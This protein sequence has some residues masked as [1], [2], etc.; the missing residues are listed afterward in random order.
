MVCTVPVKGHIAV[1]FFHENMQSGGDYETKD[2]HRNLAEF[3]ADVARSNTVEDAREA[4]VEAT[5]IGLSGRSFA[6]TLGACGLRSVYR[7]PWWGADT[8]PRSQRAL[9]GGLRPGLEVHQYLHW[10]RCGTNL[11]ILETRICV[12]L[13]CRQRCRKRTTRR[14]LSPMDSWKCWSILLECLRC[15][16]T[17]QGPPPDRQ[18][19]G[20]RSQR[21]RQLSDAARD[22]QGDQRNMSSTRGIPPSRS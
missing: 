2:H 13:R 17:A 9:G 14:A 12:V 3:T 4:Y 8:C 10:N 22:Q 21:A 16:K 7:P 5:K 6:K 20:I 11:L 15:R 1:G 18:R 19:T